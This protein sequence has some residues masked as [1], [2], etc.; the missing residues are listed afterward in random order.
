M[1]IK[2]AGFNKTADLGFQF[3]PGTANSKSGMIIIFYF[4]GG[5]F[6]F[7]RDYQYLINIFSLDNE[8]LS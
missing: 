1:N 8:R 2:G 3:S 5:E 4:P 7:L 6:G